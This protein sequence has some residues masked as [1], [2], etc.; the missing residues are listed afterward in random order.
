MYAFSMT[1]CENCFIWNKIILSNN[2]DNGKIKICFYLRNISLYH[3]FK[4]N[5]NNCCNI[6]L[7]FCTS[8]LVF[9][10]TLCYVKKKAGC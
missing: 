3:I 5:T 2:N 6:T 7:W 10:C 1:E 4:F 9:S 8:N